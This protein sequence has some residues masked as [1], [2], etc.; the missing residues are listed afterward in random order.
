MATGATC[1]HCGSSTN[2]AIVSNLLS[3]EDVQLQEIDAQISRTE[4]LLKEL[5]LKRSLLRKNRN[6]QSSPI[7]RLPTELTSEIFKALDLV[8]WEE[9]TG[10]D[11]DDGLEIETTREHNSHGVVLLPILIGSVCSTWRELSLSMASL[12]SSITLELDNPSAA[13]PTFLDDCL[14]RS[15]LHA[16]RI[17]LRC[18]RLHAQNEDV[19]LRVMNIVGRFSERWCHIIFCLPLPCYDVLHFVQGRLPMLTSISLRLTTGSLWDPITM[20]SVAPQLQ[21]VR[22]HGDS[23]FNSRSLPLPLAHLTSL[24]GYFIQDMDFPNILSVTPRLIHGEFIILGPSDPM[25]QVVA[26]VFHLKLLKLHVYRG[27]LIL[28]SLLDRITL[29]DVHEMSFRFTPSTDVYYSFPALNFLSFVSRSSCALQTLKIQ[30]IDHL[31]MNDD[32]LL[33]C[34]RA[35]PSL[36]DLTLC[37]R[38][39]TNQTICNLNPNLFHLLPNLRMLSITSQDLEVN[40]AHLYDTLFA[41]WSPADVSEIAQLRSVTIS[42]VG[43]IDDIVDPMGF[44][45]LT[46]LQDDGMEIFVDK[47]VQQAGSIGL[48]EV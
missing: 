21:E 1:I 19:V 10:D 2:S 5:L 47:I 27:P 17:H 38:G 48:D 6:L 31:I 39:I 35:I 22:C 3:D 37:V 18:Q 32:I 45:P 12:W 26:E 13:Y 11:G 40:L 7:L 33:D 20:F 44:Y 41:R 8:F 24:S 23:Y 4:K 28:D 15:G 16:L 14:S 34:I 30:G 36:T 43:F 29:P 25:P 9:G 46:H 42:A